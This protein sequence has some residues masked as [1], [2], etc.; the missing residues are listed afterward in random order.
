MRFFLY[1][2]IFIILTMISVPLKGQSDKDPPV[3]PGFSLVTINQTT[4]LTEMTWSLSP[5]PDVAGYVV[6]LFRYGE[7]YAIDTIY[8]PSATN[9][10]VLRPGTIHYPETYVVA[11]IDYSGNISPLSNDLSTIYNESVLDSCYKKIK[12]SWTKYQSVPVKVTGYDVYASVN[13]GT[14][15]LAGHTSD[16]VTSFVLDEFT[17]GSEYCFTTKAILENGQ[18]AASNKSCVVVKMQN[19]PL[20]INADYATVTADGDISLSFS[21]DSGSEIDLFSLERRSGYSGSFDQIAQVRTDIKSVAYTDRDVD[22]NVVN[23]YRLS[24]VNNCNVRVVSSNFASNIVL[25]T[26]NTGN[27]II[28]QWTGYHD[29][30]GSVSSYTIYTDTGNGFSESGK[31]GPADTTFSIRISDIMYALAQGKVCF[32]VSCTESDNPYGIAGESQSNETCTDLE[33]VVT[34]PNIFTP[35]GDLKNDLFRPVVTFTPADYHLVITDRKGKTLFETRDFMDSW[36]GSDNGNMV[37]EGVYI[38]FL[39]IKTPTGKSISRTG[40][41]TVVKN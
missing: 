8:N 36:N 39:K 26:Q 24:A 29:W 32:Y 10:S 16:T 37:P 14:W 7:G 20:W 5:S 38:W 34:I 3:S 12:I 23:F 6:Y 31:T 1:H 9:Y 22:R 30:N 11:A 21:I 28:L 41:V 2:I 27:E 25:T 40:T 17:H 35:D 18:V 19:P 15:Y 4:G 33:E 13:S